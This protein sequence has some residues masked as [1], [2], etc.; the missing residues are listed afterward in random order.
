MAAQGF[1]GW[2][3]FVLFVV[4]I[5]SAAAGERPTPDAT[6]AESPAIAEVPSSVE[7]PAAVLRGRYLELLRDSADKARPDLSA[8]VPELIDF[9]AT[10]RPQTGVAFADVDRM[11]NGLRVRLEH[12]RHRLVLEKMRIEAETKRAAR[13]AASRGRPIDVA[14]GAGGGLTAA[15][16]QELIDLIT[17]TV[18]PE[19]WDVNGGNGRIMFYS[20]LNVLVI[21]A[22][23][24]VHEQVGG[25]LGQLK[26]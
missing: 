17:N 6:S 13:S 23:G 11:R 20:P 3:S 7:R 8:V 10:L 16:A 18:A 21:R 2:V 14:T 4:S 5:G 22:T 9:A 19:S 15:R 1:I 24:E 25:T 12:L 26:R